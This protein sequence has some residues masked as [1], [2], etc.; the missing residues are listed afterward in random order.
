MA[1][2]DM[3]TLKFEN[4][5][6]TQK[7]LFPSYIMKKQLFFLRKQKISLDFYFWHKVKIILEE[8]QVVY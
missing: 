8:R 4:I 6:F 1:N 5:C 2:W 7:N 3:K